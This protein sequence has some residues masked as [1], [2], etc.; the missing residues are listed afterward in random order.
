M[1]ILIQTRLKNE[2]IL[3]VGKNKN[4]TYSKPFHCCYLSEICQH[5]QSE[6]DLVNIFTV[7]IM[8]AL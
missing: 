1:E 7:L 5:N 3:G 8:F 6:E 4:K 2:I